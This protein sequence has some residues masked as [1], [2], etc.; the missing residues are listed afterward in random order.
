MKAA[1]KSVAK[2]AGLRRED[3]A[4]VRMLLERHALALAPRRERRDRGRILCYHTV[5]QPRS[6]TNDVTPD[7][8]VR[9]IETA[10]DAGFCFVPARNIAETGGSPDELAI[11]F[12]DGWTSV[13]R[14][15]A[16]I[17][18][19]FHIPWT[20]F[21]VSDWSSHVGDFAAGN[22]LHW[23]ELAKVLD[24]GGE[25]GSHS[26]T[27]PDFAKLAPAVMTEELNR[28]RDEIARNLGIAPTAFAI[29]YG[30]SMN[31]TSDAQ[32][33]AR[34]AG[35]EVIYAQ[36]EN[37]RP[38]GTIARTFITKFDDVRLFKA[39]LDG[40]FDNWEEWL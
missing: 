28:S 3:A 15:A 13:L 24:F 5:G 14:T 2:A 25:I 36:S 26:V 20:L 32:A 11:T 33:A 12:D 18:D 27:H 38:A 17:L 8:F 35:Y 9:H 31:W 40:A 22:I 34:A 10:L 21:V 7:T 16:P 29:P 39:A 1:L 19:R 6:G 37:L 23:R 4:A 30:Q